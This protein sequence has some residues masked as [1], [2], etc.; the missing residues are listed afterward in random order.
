MYKNKTNI[1]RQ[2]KKILL[3]G[4]FGPFGVDNEYGRKENIMELFHNQVTKA[5]GMASLRFHHRSFGLYFLAANLDADVTVL[6][7]PSKRRFAKEL[8]GNYDYVGIS[9]ITPNFVKAREMARMIRQI[10][11]GSK[12]LLGGHGAAIE[13]VE[14]LIDCD[15]VI[16]GEGIGPMRAL[17]GQ[18]PCDPITHP[19]L[20]STQY[21]KIFGVPVP[22]TTNVLVPGVGCVNACKFCSTSHFFGRSYTSF[23]NT[24]TELFDTICDIAQKTGIDS[25]FVM[26]ENFLK[27]RNR[28]MDLL[29]NMESAGRYF[30]FSV[31][32][33]A[34]AI[35][36]FGI[37]NM[38][39]MGITFVW[40]GVESSCEK[41]NYEK[42]AGIDPKPLIKKLRD[43][44]ISVMASG[45]LC[46]EHHT[47]DNIQK[48]IDYLIGLESD[49]VQFMLLTPLPVTALYND[50]KKRGLLRKDLPFE[51]WHGQKMM[52]WNHPNF[53][54]DEPEKWMEAAFKKDYEVNSSSM[55]RMIET[56]TR[57]YETFSAMTKVDDCIK[58]QIEGRRQSMIQYS[59]MLPTI[60][61]YAVNEKEK[62][63]AIALQARIQNL[64]RGSLGPIHKLGCIGVK[65]CA[66]AWK[67]RL[68][69]RG[70]AIQP[71]TIV[72]HYT[73]EENKKRQEEGHTL[74]PKFFGRGKKEILPAA[75]MV[76][77]TIK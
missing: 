73:A 18:D 36:A 4:V 59:M 20:P 26:D 69:L 39:R 68:K 51:E 44:G 65:A 3:A 67:T 47:P 13:G 9:F 66:A 19:A 53:P 76:P 2:K 23:I 32:S 55:Y 37:E 48:D 71:K 54:G 77:V 22:G 52:S 34:E 33:S 50:H 1:T 75:A 61:K 16:K 41:G 12:I 30:E 63:K 62:E 31:F 10:S 70:E 5:Q 29:A 25:F 7:F 49:F 43:H 6:D 72:E 17:L 35:T 14:T 45:I 42:N 11:P 46:M 21:R 57:G 64:A 27:D 40:I 38:V 28:A 58:A 8:K 15:H 60:A 56:C 74:I 24:G